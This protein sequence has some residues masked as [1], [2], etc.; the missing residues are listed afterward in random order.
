M[1]MTIGLIIGFAGG[2][3]ARS[4][5]TTIKEWFSGLK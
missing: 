1:F 4:R 2:W 5:V 3:M